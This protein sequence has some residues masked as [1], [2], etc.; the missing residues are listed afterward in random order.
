MAQ[1]F[2]GLE[3]FNKFV[4]GLIKDSK[5]IAPLQAYNRY[6]LSEITPE[7]VKDLKLSGFRTVESL[8]SY[9]YKI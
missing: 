9:I 7:N 5:L 4:E 6:Y 1:F 2:L 3:N 8:K